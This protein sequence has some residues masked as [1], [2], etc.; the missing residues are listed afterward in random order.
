MLHTTCKIRFKSNDKLLL[1]R[2][3]SCS[4]TDFLTYHIFK[5]FLFSKHFRLSP[6]FQTFLNFFVWVQRWESLNVRMFSN[7][8]WRWCWIFEWNEILRLNVFYR[9]SSACESKIHS[10]TGNCSSLEVIDPLWSLCNLLGS[11]V[12]W[13]KNWPFCKIHVFVQCK[14]KLRGTSMRLRSANWLLRRTLRS[15]A[16]NLVIKILCMLLSRLKVSYNVCRYGVC[17][18]SCGQVSPSPPFPNCL[19][20]TRNYR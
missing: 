14:S 2:C 17:R 11:G 5:T 1:V 9:L 3:S 13:G 6:L 7:T 18:Y 8:I 10:I 20:N 15:N 19:K 12:N 4:N 16:V